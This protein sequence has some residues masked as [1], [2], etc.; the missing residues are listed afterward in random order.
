MENL[1]LSLLKKMYAEI[2]DDDLYQMFIEVLNQHAAGSKNIFFH[3][4]LHGQDMTSQEKSLLDLRGL[5]REE[6]FKKLKTLPF[7]IRLNNVQLVD[8]KIKE[9]SRQTFLATREPANCNLYYT[10]SPAY[11]GLSMHIDQQETYILQLRGSKRWLLV[12]DAEGELLKHYNNP[13]TF[14]EVPGRAYEE[15]VTQAG[16][17]YHIPLGVPHKAEAEGEEPSIHLNFA[18]IVTLKQDL[19]NL[20]FNDFYTTLDLNT[21][22]H[23]VL[24]TEDIPK[25]LK[26]LRSYFDDH[27][28][29]ARAQEFSTKL[30]SRMLGYLKH[31]RNTRG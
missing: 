6:F 21:N 8:P 23:S 4:F 31:G 13:A 5:E 10:P 26:H 25:I 9:V 20:F 17:T 11:P 28:E 3:L 16:D 19:Y 22:S 15:V 24:S 27:D 12:K 1:T 29:S 14:K 7:S 2:T 30:Q 18:E